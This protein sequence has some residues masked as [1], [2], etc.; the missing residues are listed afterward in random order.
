MARRAAWLSGVW[1]VHTSN[2]SLGLDLSS[3]GPVSVS[4]MEISSVKVA[5]V[6][7]A[8]TVMVDSV[9]ALSKESL[10]PLDLRNGEAHYL[11]LGRAAFPALDE[12]A[13]VVQRLG[14]FVARLAGDQTPPKVCIFER[15]RLRAAFARVSS[16]IRHWGPSIVGRGSP[17]RRASSG[18]SSNSGIVPSLSRFLV[19]RL[20]YGGGDL[21]RHS[22]RGAS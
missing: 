18:K 20:H 3:G 17:G 5:S 11:R 9:G 8:R 6:A 15:E 4:S 16:W 13:K 10:Q 14:D 19:S 1:T 2:R 22:D 12:I 21:V 7:A